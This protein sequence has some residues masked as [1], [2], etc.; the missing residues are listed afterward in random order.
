MDDLKERLSEIKK[1]G[2]KTYQ[3][4]DLALDTARANEEFQI[5]GSYLY[6]LSFDGT[7]FNIR[8]NS[9]SND[10]IPLRA[11]RSVSGIFYR[12]FL[13]H[14]AQAGKIAKLLIGVKTEFSVEDW[15]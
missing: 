2:T 5:Q 1:F 15:S 10:L 9:I 11:H 6:A 7:D 14:T 13:T 4:I 12:I 8:L 3:V